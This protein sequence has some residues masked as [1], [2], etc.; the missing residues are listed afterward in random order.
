M[1]K[2]AT[3]TG[4]SGLL[5]AALLAVGCTE[6]V[7]PA[8]RGPGTPQFDVAA[9]GIALD[10]VNGTLP[11]QGTALLKGFNPTNPHLGD[12]IIVTFFWVGSTNTNI[13]TSVTDH[14]ADGTA[15]GNT[16][17]PVE[18]VSAGG[19]SM[20][21]YVATN[22]QNFPEGTF[23]SGEKILVVQADLASS[24][25]DGGIMMSAFTGVSTVAAQAMGG[26]SK[27]FGSGSSFPTV[28]DPGALA[29]DANALAYGVTMSN[30]VVGVDP[31]VG[32]TTITVL[33]DAAVVTEANYA[34]QANAGS[35]DPQWSWHFNSPSTWLA[36]ALVLN[37]PSPAPG[38]LTVTTSTTGSSLDPDGYTVTVDGALSRAIAI[39][40]SVT[41]TGLSAGSHSVALSGVAANCVVSGG[42]SKTATVPAGGTVTAS[43]TVICSTT[44]KLTGGGKLGDGRN[45][46]SFGSEAKQTGGEV[47]W[48]QHCLDGVQAGSS[49][50]PIGNFTFH[51]TMTVGSY[52]AVTGSPSCRTW[53]GTGT[54]NDKDIPSRSGTYS[55][56]VNAA[57]DNGEPGRGTD[58]IDITIGGYHNF[59]YLTGGNIQRQK[60]N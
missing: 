44:S 60:S 6:S 43:F 51:G 36:T 25:Q 52:G 53:S 3:W 33:S 14:L 17:T 8:R 10:Q 9:N 27:A 38:N 56:T 57:C 11:E 42:N 55:F 1:D 47:E 37:P 22:V 19:I 29:I 12:A 23:P 45:F 16:Y 24:I 34:V 13:I 48:V 26:H 20:A 28:A 49:T 58:F 46:A 5:A 31:P 18:F 21:T 41:F 7:G 35:V 59:G 50:C 4:L 15:V 39:N 32:F 2:S 40:G 54:V 30:A